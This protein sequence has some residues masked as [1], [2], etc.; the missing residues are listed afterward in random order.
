MLLDPTALAIV[1]ALGCIAAIVGGMGG[2][3]TGIILTAALA[4]FI[5][6][7]AVKGQPDAYGPEL[8]AQL[9]EPYLQEAQRVLQEGIVADADLVDAGLIFGTGFAPF[10]GGPLHYLQHGKTPGR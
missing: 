5:G 4:P 2:F 8:V 7:K 6:V 3:G 10:R 9:I 1:A